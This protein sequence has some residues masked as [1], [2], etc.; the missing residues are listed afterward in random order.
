MVVRAR[1]AAPIA[2]MRVGFLPGV[3]V[4]AR[5]VVDG[6]VGFLLIITSCSR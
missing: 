5:P 4:S 1:I 2:S 6:G 3:E